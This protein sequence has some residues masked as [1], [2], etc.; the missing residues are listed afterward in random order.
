MP[1]FTSGLLLTIFRLTL[2]LILTDYKTYVRLTFHF[3]IYSIV[4][5]SRMY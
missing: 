2:G 3:M 4:I 1:L 5:T